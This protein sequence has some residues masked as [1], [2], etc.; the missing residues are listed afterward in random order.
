MHQQDATNQNM[1]QHSLVKHHWLMSEDM[2]GCVELCTT[3]TMQLN[4]IK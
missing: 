4:L 3:G 1:T 2:I